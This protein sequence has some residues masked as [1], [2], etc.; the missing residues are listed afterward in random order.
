MDF[1]IIS[2]V[3]G[4]VFGAV[5]GSVIVY[6]NDRKNIR[7]KQF[8]EELITFNNIFIDIEQEI[9]LE[10]TEVYLVISRNRKRADTAIERICIHINRRKCIKLKALYENYNNNKAQNEHFKIKT[11]NR[12]LDFF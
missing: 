5:V 2:A 8:R 9:K 10:P 11:I 12:I 4:A 7:Y 3:I 6:F 1:S